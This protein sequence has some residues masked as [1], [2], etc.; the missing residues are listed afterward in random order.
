[1]SSVALLAALSALATASCSSGSDDE[2]ATATPSATP[3]PTAAPRDPDAA[4]G[5]YEQ[6]VQ[7]VRSQELER[8]WALYAASIPGD[9]SQH[10]ADAGCDF[11]AFSVEFP[12]IGHLF[13]SA[14]PFEILERFASSVARTAVE[15]SL[16]GA[17]GRTFLMTLV[18]T[19][20]HEDY[21]VRFFNSG[22]TSLIP[23]VPDP[24]QPPEDPQ[25]WCGIWAGAR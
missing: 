4:V 15:L 7:V 16:R 11:G 5:I 23:G 14:A 25:G 2:A 22:R 6:F 8:A 20:P 9:T 18:R 17:D 3:A 19:E 24:Q 12:K 21:R 13:E 1:M 10:R